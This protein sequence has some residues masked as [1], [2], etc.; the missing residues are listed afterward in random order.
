MVSFIPVND[1]LIQSATMD[2]NFRRLAALESLLPIAYH[3]VSLAEESLGVVEYANQLFCDMVGRTPDE[4]VGRSVL[5]ITAP[6]D[7]EDS[8]TRMR[9]RR[10]SE[11]RQEE[12]PRNFITPDGRVVP[13]W[14]NSAVYHDPITKHP[15]SMSL[16]TPRLETDK[17]V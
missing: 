2:R 8:V 6:S 9:A 7:R 16:S 5:E 14:L 11:G 12:V 15:V 13:V 4:V 1:P 3:R 17:S 10:S